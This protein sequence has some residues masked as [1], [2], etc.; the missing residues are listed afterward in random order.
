MLSS[1]TGGE[2]HISPRKLPKAP[3][4]ED[5]NAEDASALPPVPAVLKK[6]KAVTPERDDQ[7]ANKPPVTPSPK[8]VSH[9]IELP[10]GLTV[11]GLKSR[12]DGKKVK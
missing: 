1:H 10:E 5:T 9:P 12:L 8:K 2:V 3:T 11:S 4:S 6:T 7:K